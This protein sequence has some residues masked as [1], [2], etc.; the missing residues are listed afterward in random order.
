MTAPWEGIHDWSAAEYHADVHTAKPSLSA[1]L[2]WTLV[3]Q[4]PKHAWTR[5]PR[6]NPD[7]QRVEEDRFSVG[8]VAHAI[9]LEGADIVHVC[10]YDS[11]RSNDAKA[12]REDARAL[13]KVPLLAHQVAEVEQM[14]VAIFA[15]LA[16][17]DAQ[18]PLFSNGQAERSLVWEE[19]GVTCRARVDWL[20]DD[21]AT[22]DDLKT[23]GQEGGASPDKWERSLY[24]HGAHL[25]AAMYLRGVEK[26]TG[27]RPTF[28]WVCV[29]TQ[30]PYALSVS[31][32]SEEVIAL[33]LADFDF[34]LA[35]WKECM[36]AD[37]WPGYPMTVRRLDAPAWEVER[38][39]VRE[40]MAA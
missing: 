9:V 15:Q 1:S 29:E 36:E 30:P 18:P 33:G 3:S 4:S 14:V 39:L 8:T 35:R 6:L 21:L 20:R 27:E 13:G 26:L 17:H 37:S 32:P 11:W 22:I 31:T 19:D 24:A 10:H 12:A 28:R 23:R 40:E 16:E 38:R 7:W 2:A 25:Q 34:A 5:H